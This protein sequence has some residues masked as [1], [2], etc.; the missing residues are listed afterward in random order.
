MAIHAAKPKRRRLKHAPDSRLLFKLAVNLMDKAKLDFPKQLVEY[1]DGLMLAVFASRARRLR[2]MA[3]L[4]VGREVK[5]AGNG[6]RVE[7]TPDLVKTK[8]HDAFS[9]SPELIPYIDHYLS[10][11][12]P[13]LLA[14]RGTDAFWVSR[15]HGALSEKAVQER[16]FRWTRQWF[17]QGFGPHR[18]RHAYVTTG[19]LRASA[20]PHL[21]ATALGITGQVAEKHYNLACQIEATSRLAETLA[22]KRR[23]LRLLY[24]SVT[25]T[26]LVEYNET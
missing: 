23:E 7:L 20:Y 21:G 10:E 6:Y 12:R 19:S 16:V 24:G 4:R 2:A 13:G 22:D 14:G 9:M 17:G 11:V 15:H 8:K 18:F 1:R 5:R 26:V 25:T 3:S